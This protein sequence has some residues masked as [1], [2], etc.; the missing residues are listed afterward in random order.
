MINLQKEH[1]YRTIP[2]IFVDGAFI[3]G[4]QELIGQVKSKKLILD[5]MQ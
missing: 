3:G 5:E 2:M 4:Y 1:N